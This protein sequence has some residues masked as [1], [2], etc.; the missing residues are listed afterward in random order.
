MLRKGIEEFLEWDY[1]GAPWKF[2]EHGG[3]GGLSLRNP[4]VM[5]NICSVYNYNQSIDGY[6]DIWFSKYVKQDWNLAPREEC[7]KFSCETIYQEGTLGVHAID[8]YLTPEQCQK[9][10]TQY[11]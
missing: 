2:Q 5:F 9:I 8:R 10:K 11:K 4:S 3:N 6:E 7:S 1:I